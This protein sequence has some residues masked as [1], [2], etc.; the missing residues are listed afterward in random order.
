MSLKFRYSADY[1]DMRNEETVFYPK[2]MNRLFCDSE[3]YKI[4]GSVLEMPEHRASHLEAFIVGHTGLELNTY[5]NDRMPP[6][7]NSHLE[8][9]FIMKTIA[10]EAEVRE[11]LNLPYGKLESIPD[12]VSEEEYMNIVKNSM[13]LVS[14]GFLNQEEV[15]HEKYVFSYDNR[16]HD[17][18]DDPCVILEMVENFV[19]QNEHV[20][21]C[22]AKLCEIHVSKYVRQYHAHMFVIFKDKQ[23]ES[24]VKKI[25]NINGQI[26]PASKSDF[27]INLIIQNDCSCEQY[28][29]V[30]KNFF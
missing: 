26:Q 7:S 10:S 19:N 27:D 1:T 6:D 13:R 4:E 23:T 2:N 21:K 29:I 22:V 24:N 5:Y 28:K 16:R 18:F 9:Y 17:N 11:K 15:K 3:W 30:H 8:A 12:A 20:E 14:S 25:I